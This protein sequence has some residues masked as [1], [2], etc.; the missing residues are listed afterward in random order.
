VARWWHDEDP[1]PYEYVF[2]LDEDLEV[3]FFNA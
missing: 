3:S 1:R 2:L